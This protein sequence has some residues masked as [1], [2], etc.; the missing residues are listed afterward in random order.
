M[1][2]AEAVE[3]RGGST[4]AVTWS[5]ADPADDR[6]IAQW[7]VDQIPAAPAADILIG[8]SLGSYGA[9]VAA[10]RAL[11]AI[12]LTPLLHNSWVVDGLRS[13]TA[14]FLL[15]G[16]SADP[17]WNATLAADLTPH[18]LTIPDA[19]H[20]MFVPGPLAASAAV[21]GQVATAVEDFLD[22]VVWP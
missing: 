9:P 16:G 7:V 1:Y 5:P 20:G 21:L 6:E 10:D 15:I 8:K 13:A 11:H 18:V 19:D 22:Q 3:R 4:E 17:S 12:W 2:A 14:P